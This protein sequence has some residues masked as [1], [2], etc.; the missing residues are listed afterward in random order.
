VFVWVVAVGW[1]VVYV[2]LCCFWQ[3]WWFGYVSG[4]MFVFWLFVDVCDGFCWMGVFVL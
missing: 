3:V 1:W 4:V 2:F